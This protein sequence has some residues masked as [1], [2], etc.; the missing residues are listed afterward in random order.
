MTLLLT[1]PEAADE[2]RCSENTVYRL[3]SEGLI[4]TCDIGLRGRARTRITHK[5]LQDF[6][7]ARST[8]RPRRTA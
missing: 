2:L 8:E 1:V 4:Q 3:I 6:V 7:A 5:A